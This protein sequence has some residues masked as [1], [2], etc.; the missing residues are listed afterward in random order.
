M[1]LLLAWLL[2]AM[3]MVPLWAATPPA[4]FVI[5]NRA[6]ALYT[7]AGK[8]LPETLFSNTVSASVEAV[9]ALTLTSDWSV[10]L[11]PG[12]KALLPHILTNTGNVD[13]SYSL[14]LVNLL[15]DDFN[16]A[17]LQLVHDLNGNGMADSGEPVLLPGQP[18]LHLA[19]GQSA[20]LL[21][22]GVLPAEPDT[23]VVRISL[24]AITAGKGPLSAS[25]TDTI[26]VGAQASVR[27]T[28]RADQ[29]GTVLPGTLVNYHVVG[30]NIGDSP[31]GPT[32]MAGPQ[33][34]AILIDGVPATVLMMRDAVPPGTIY[35]PASLSTSM[36]EAIRLFRLPADPPFQY[37]TSGDDLAAVEVAV[38]SRS[39]RLNPNVT[40]DMRFAVRVKADYSGVIPNVADAFYND[41]RTPAQTTSNLVLLTV[42]R[43]RIGLAKRASQ[44][45]Y[46]YDPLTRAP[47]G[48]AKVRLSFVVESFSAV[49]LSNVQ[50]TDVLE[51]ADRYG[52]YTPSPQPGRGQYMLVAGSAQVVS[53]RNG[54][55]ASFN[56]DFKG[57]TAHAGLLAAGVTLP[58]LGAVEVSFEVR[59]NALGIDGVVYNTATATALRGNP[60]N[61]VVSDE[62]VDGS[63][64]DANGDNDPGN[65]TS[66]TPV[67]LSVP[68]ITLVK[69][70]SEPRKVEGAS[71]T[72]DI[73]FTLT[74]TN[75]GKPVATYVRVAD[76]LNCTFQMYRSPS[77]VQSW[78]LLSAPTSGNGLLRSNAGFTGNAPCATAQMQESNA[79]LAMPSEPQ[80]MLTDGTRHLDPGASEV[81]RFTVRFVI[82]PLAKSADRTF[83][84]RAYSASFDR[85]DAS[86][87]QIF[88]A[89]ASSV[90]QQVIDPSGVIYQALTRQPVADATVRLLRLS[91]DGAS[92]GPITADQVMSVKNTHYTFNPDGSVSMKTGADGA[93]YFYFNS[94]PVT[95]NCEY[96]L[97]VTVPAGG[98]VAS[99][100]NLIP[101]LPGRVPD[102]IGAV[103]E[104]S[105][106]PPVGSPTPYYF[107]MRLGPGLPDI[108]NNHIALDPAPTIGTLLLEKKS[109]K[110]VIEIGASLEY[111]LRLKNVSGKTLT[112][113][114][115]EDRLPPGFRYLS[116]SARLE[117][118][119]IDDP[120]GAQSSVLQFSFP[121]L[122]LENG[123]E[124][125]LAYR[126]QSGIGTPLGDAVNRA[127]A[128]SGDY[129]SNLAQ[130]KVRV[131]GGVFS[132]EAYLFGKVFL[133]CNK[134][135]IQGH[136]EVGIPG[137]RLIMEDGTGVVT[138]VEGK[139]SLYGLRA[140]THVLKLDATTLPPGAHLEV[141]DSRNSGQADSRFVDLKNGEL[142]KAN[143]AVDN[144]EAPAVKE[145]VE[146]R[147]RALADRPDTESLAVS[148]VRLD[149]QAPSALPLDQVRRREPS[150]ELTPT[151]ISRSTAPVL[152]APAA[153]PAA[154]F[155]PVKPRELTGPSGLP[156]S[157][158]SMLPR[159][160]LEDLLPKQDN[161][162]AFLDL[163][164][165]DTL[166]APMANV[167]V[168]GQLGATL[169]LSVN[170]RQIQMSRVGKRARLADKQLEAWEYIGVDLLP[171]E[172]LLLLE[173]V[174]SFGTVRGSESIKVIA[175][176]KIG[177][178]EIDAPKT[179]VADAV[180]PVRIKVR[181][182]DDKGVLVTARTQLTLEVDNGLWETKDLNPTEPGTQVFLEGG[183]A[184]Y[185]IIPPNNPL[186]A[187]VRVSS[188]VLQKEVKIA[189]LPE[190]RPLIGA[191]ILEGILDFRKKGLLPVG[192]S[193]RDAFEQKLRN[194][195]R[196]S[197]DGKRGTSGR[198]AFYLKGV[199]RGEY[200]LTAA[201][202]SDKTTRERLFRDIQP[203]KFY[204]I[205]GDS[206]TK[207]FDA[208]STERL[209]LRIDHQKSWLLFGDFTS[210]GEGDIR[211]L[212]QYSRAAT[213]AKYHY[214]NDKVSANVYASHD[215]LTQTVLEIPANG[216]SGPYQLGSGGEFK[217]N[218][219]KVEILV[220]DRR[221]PG[222]ILQTTVLSRFTD[223][224]IEPLSGQLRFAAPLASL[225]QNLNPRFIRITYEL[226]AGGP[227]AWKGG[228]DGQYKLSDSLQVGASYAHDATPG[229]QL[230]LSGLTAVI[231]LDPKS[232]VTAE[233]ARSETDASG[234]GMAARA[235]WIKESEDFKIRAQATR[236]DGN[237]DNITS[238]FGKGRT[239]ATADA[240]YSIG[241]ATTL[242][243]EAI[244]SKDD[245]AKSERAGVL[246]SAATRLGESVEASLG[247]RLSRDTVPQPLASTVPAPTNDGPVEM[248]TVRGRLGMPIPGVDGAKAYVELEQDVRDKDKRMVALGGDYQVSQKARLYGRYE[249]LSSLGSPYALN[250]AVQNNVAVFGL[251][252]SYLQDGRTFNEFRLRDTINGRELQAASGLRK[253]WQVGEGLRV[254]ASYENTKAFAGVQGSNSTAV[255]GTLEYTPD[256][257]SRLY[258]SLEARAADSG[259]SYVN[260][261]GFAY[262]IDKDWSMLGRSAI[263]MQK[264]N[265]DHSS[266]LQSRQQI[267]LAWRQVDVDRWNALGRYEY[268]L[269]DTVGG[270]APLKDAS[271]TVSLHVNY[272]P[273]RAF[274]A[275]GRYAFKWGKE[276]DPL[277]STEFKAHLLYGRITKDIARDIDVSLQ[278]AYT[279]GQGSA[280]KH[281]IGLEVGYQMVA[282]LWLSVG[283]NAVGFRDDALTGSEYL[284]RGVYLRLRYK[285]D[286]GLLK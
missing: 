30:T 153:A 188:G 177:R 42:A 272:Q 150:G 260:T 143:F 164:N 244:Y 158:E 82:A 115:V 13:S 185:S 40:T 145:E 41:G 240:S 110:A 35:Q 276:T 286:E 282:N 25:N 79:Y 237:F 149:L 250:A 204:P 86:G 125:T 208:Q 267:G 139:Y 127:Q 258:A 81:I 87:A 214:E 2:A 69:T 21:V 233:V 106:A 163:R 217:E 124:V 44:P 76:N 109:T 242:R 269:K 61:G 167:R 154:V 227:A 191:G 221:Q 107:M 226:D 37:R 123:K 121:T 251:E 19:P 218:S 55:T 54:A 58:P 52:T 49:A 277:L 243:T 178:I 161:T 23:A 236:S 239:E 192:Q 151:G 184:E 283:Y 29:A 36:P 165:G 27:L 3:G 256:P 175:P 200:L 102:G 64:P 14:S 245:V 228:A 90:T 268:N 28:K 130:R 241:K 116:A 206:S 117:G 20:T 262:K 186:D 17:G 170:G 132:D 88:A 174:D 96:G 249:V 85:Q 53:L 222:V 32:P 75:S 176:G 193:P 285:F 210:A 273:E 183:Q 195:S 140:I 104:Q 209:Y 265:S 24:S 253:T 101:P 68:G 80:L 111:T 38:A 15:G 18:S 234:K 223:Y 171:G 57:T 83:T 136:E 194:F 22:I 31:A 133:D 156:P 278:S 63:A 95:Q 187:I 26:R 196:E 252:T 141:L 60:G 216:T 10:S 120:A 1:R 280:R 166:P 8:A 65:D 180:T 77:P 59:I 264:T 126:V 56:P 172:N 207:L 74:V 108:V 173:A 71:R 66:P 159:V 261:L 128:A 6:E 271:H 220:R 155:E 274:T 254:G 7:P 98:D 238:G 34:T 211:K 114:T 229:N 113:Y 5:K 199:V 70:V 281:A 205:Y 263:S 219:E 224:A 73:D 105:T 169:Q 146:R 135:G 230:T 179:A 157:P 129:T 99:P 119:K 152:A 93:Y 270:A 100:S 257:R 51:R 225:D 138:D 9:E 197:A 181:L 247:I 162:L 134:D 189:Y 231:K 137:V 212:S 259:D 94:P 246:V 4:G 160:D 89:A 147:R 118:A 201:Y 43:D 148:K 91:C 279:W 144:C 168:K 182:T 142:H 213:G 284:N 122:T 45:V 50:I 275:S 255:T 198:A 248:V 202:D 232:V 78:R 84:N 48:I 16:L 203:D 67:L 97:S 215:S 72:W 103:Q 11:P 112:G 47:L 190:L 33:G 39:F 46:E 266:L 62:S 131:E 92:A 12:S 235:E